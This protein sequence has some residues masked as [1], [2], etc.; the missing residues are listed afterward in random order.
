MPKTLVVV[1]KCQQCGYTTTRDDLAAAN[2]AESAHIIQTG[3]SWIHTV[4][5][6]Q[7]AQN[8]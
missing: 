2:K 5:T 3:H 6:R 4:A 7:E 8:A 1:V